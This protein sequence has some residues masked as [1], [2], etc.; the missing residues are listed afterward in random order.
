VSGGVGFDYLS[1]KVDRELTDLG[2][3][4]VVVPRKGK[5]S[6]AR[7]AEEYR[8]ALRRTDAVYLIGPY[9]ELIATL[10][11]DHGT[12]RL[13]DVV[14]VAV[15]L[16]ELVDIRMR[17]RVVRPAAASH[18]ATQ[19][20]IN[21]FGHPLGVATHVHLAR[22]TFIKAWR[23]ESP[24]CGPRAL[25]PKPDPRTRGKTAYPVSLIQPP[26]QRCSRTFSAAT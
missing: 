11:K 26:A 18:R 12:R 2:V 20:R 13:V 14:H 21:I 16:D 1:A 17:G 4:N 22:L 15:V 24:I 8:N 10:R 25:R 6:Q 23:R 19:C 5:T 3:T 9:R 7:R